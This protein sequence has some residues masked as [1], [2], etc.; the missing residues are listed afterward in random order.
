MIRC[1]G[2]DMEEY[3]IGK[4]L[5]AVFNLIK[6]RIDESEHLQFVHK[7]TGTNG[8]IIAYLANN[9]GKDIFQKDIEQ[10]FTVARSTASRVISLLVDKGL[11][12][13]T[14]VDYDARL[15]K[16]ELTKEA[17]ALHEDI[18]SHISGIESRLTDG[19][20]QEEVIQ[21]QG[22]IER[23]KRNMSKEEVDS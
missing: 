12:T 18:D 16:L 6:R 14:P 3:K 9:A 1:I 20:S 22:F 15:K 11:V 23:M 4:E 5:H 10:E 8:W 21:L 2:V 17:L 13:R 19:F 7:I